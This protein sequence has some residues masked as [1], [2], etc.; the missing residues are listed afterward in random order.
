MVSETTLHGFFRSSATYRV[1]IALNLKGVDYSHRTYR[2]REGEQRAGTFLALNP[3]GLVPALEIN[4]ELLTQSLAICEFLD[5][6]HPAP[7]LLP[8]HPLARAKVRAFA[9]VIACDVHP[10]QNLRV[11]ARLDASGLSAD[12]VTRWARDAITDGLDAC[13]ALIAHEKGGFCFGDHVSLADI[14]LVPQLINAR[15]FDVDLR[16]PRLL[17]IETNCLAMDEFVR[18]APE[19]QPDAA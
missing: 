7:P 1:R 13:N 15:R 8:A 16:W 6:I 12:K 14:C 18:A 4:D 19:R 3:Q 2:L 9:Q 17:E 5:E 10:L 11:L